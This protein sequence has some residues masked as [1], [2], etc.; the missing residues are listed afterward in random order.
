MFA[1]GCVGFSALRIFRIVALRYDFEY[2]ILSILN[3]N[4]CSF[5]MFLM[6]GL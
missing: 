6:D 2:V 3:L 5:N 4:L 1:K